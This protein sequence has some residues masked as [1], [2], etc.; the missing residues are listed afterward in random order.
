MKITRIET[1]P[2]PMGYRDF[3]VCRVH[4]DEGITGIGEPYPAGPNDAVA[5]VIADFA[6]WLEGKDPRDI[7]GIWQHLYAHSRFPGGSVVLAAISGIE[8]ALWDISGKAAGL[9]VYRLLGG[10]CRDRIRVYQS[11]GGSTPEACAESAVRLVETYGYTALKMSPHPPHAEALPWPAVV[12][13][14]A[15][16]LAAVRDA[17]GPDVEIGLDPHAR[18]FEPVKAQQ[19]AEALRPYNPFFFEEPLRPE[20]VEALAVFKRTCPIPVATGEMLYTTFGF[21]ELLEKQAADIIQPDVCICGGLLEMKKIA[22]IAEAH[23]ISVAPHN[24]TGP[25]AT[26]VN[27]HFAASTH[28]FL[29]L[30]YH[31]DD[32]GPRADLLQRPVQ[33]KDGYLEVPEAPGLGADLSEAAIP[34]RPIRN[35]R[36]GAPLRPDGAADFI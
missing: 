4:T 11:C 13:G 10:K 28:N 35:W 3:L 26:A 31:P 15:A 9:P 16:R 14:A 18:I 21:R 17:V 8:H 24:P 6:T 23:Y 33:L 19:M 34:E 22:A 7:T 1:L 36:R 29:I 27:V 2:A 12:R 25:I 20:N 32:A 5:A 30:E